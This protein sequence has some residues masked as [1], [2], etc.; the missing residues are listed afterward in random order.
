MRRDQP[1]DGTEP[2]TDRDTHRFSSRRRQVLAGLGTSAVIAGTGISPAV[3]ASHV[4]F[5]L[6]NVGASAW[7][8]TD[9]D[10]D[11]IAEQGVDNPTLTLQVGQRYVVEN[12]GDP[13]HPLAFLNDDG[14]TLLS[15]S[16]DG[17]FEDDPDVDWEDTNG[18]VAFTVTED[19][20]A[21]LDSYVCTVH[22][23]MVGSVQTDTDDRPTASVSF[24]D[25]ETVGDTV[26][27]DK[28]EM[29]A[30]GFVTIHDSTLLDGEV[31]PSVVGVSGFLEPGTHD[32][33]E[34]QFDSLLTEN[35][36]LIAM[37]HRDTTGSEEYE[38]VE[39]DGEE[40]GAYLDDDG[41]AVTDPGEVSVVGDAAALFTDTR[42]DGETI[43][44]DEVRVDDGGFL[45]MHDSTLLDGEVLSSSIG[46]SA[47]LE[48]GVHEA[49]EVTF[50]DPLTEDDTLIAMPHRDTTGSEEFEFIETDG[51]EDGAYV[52]PDG[53]AITNAAQ[54]AVSAPAAAT[55]SDQDSTGTFVTVDE[56]R[57]EDGGFVAI[58]D[59]TL[60]DGEVL[61]S[62]IGVSAF[63]EPGVH[64][65]VRADLL[66]P[67]GEAD[68]LIAM[69]HRDTTGSEEFEFIETDGA[70]DGAYIDLEGNAVTD[71]A[72]VT[73]IDY[74]TPDGAVTF[75]TPEDGAT[76]VSPVEWA[77]DVEGFVVE[78]ATAGLNDG[79]GHL[80][81]LVDRPFFEPGEEIPSAED[82][83]HYGDG[84]TTAEIELE[85]GEY[86]LRLQA[87]D[88]LHNA[89]DL[90]DTVD[91]EV[92]EDTVEDPAPA[93]DAVPGFGIGAAIASLG[94]AAYLLRE[95]LTGEDEQS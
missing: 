82:S 72:E 15:Q 64:E 84:Q 34:V 79:A 9:A 40:D 73:P 46:V 33:I 8:V 57:V 54:V 41:E 3:A 22:P 81:V 29:S 61:G 21:E 4:G 10:V 2:T 13:G 25:Q 12:L 35:D 66:E 39:T 45:A 92:V 93:D 67:L 48:P 7:E 43:T 18:E 38:F 65:D 95:R 17:T 90:G 89:Y 56:V 86:T 59:S 36:T 20:A 71:A 42:T 23:S 55:F 27:V 91:I 94:G 80:H 49:V 16:T 77:A 83:I 32:D 76:V 51:A 78:P 63:L 30:G 52:G 69:P 87:G 68:T 53:E 11:S 19:L 58:H 88:A 70:E 60:F 1:S 47:F 14:N 26:V 74:E 75:T 28:V 31:I 6:D 62:S 24:V 50:L 37:P 5:T 85:P 44:V